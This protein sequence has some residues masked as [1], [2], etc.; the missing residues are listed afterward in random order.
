M[1]WPPTGL[2]ASSEQNPCMDPCTSL[3]TGMGWGPLFKNIGWQSW[4][5]IV[6]ETF[7]LGLQVDIKHRNESFQAPTPLAGS[8]IVK[9]L[10][11]FNPTLRKMGTKTGVTTTSLK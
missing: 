9:T 8:S 5:L 6:N 2:P 7:S 3:G 1:S 11:L 4:K 10:F